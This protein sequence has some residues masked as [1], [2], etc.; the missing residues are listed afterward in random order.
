MADG[1]NVDPVALH[2]GSNDM[3]SATGEAALDFTSHEDGLADAA[4]GWIGSSQLALGELAGRWAL[5]HDHH[6]LQLDGLASHVAEAMFCYI[7]NEHG[8]AQAFGSVRE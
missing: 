3:F 4:P 1:F 6:T 7:T 5:R 8:S 2:V